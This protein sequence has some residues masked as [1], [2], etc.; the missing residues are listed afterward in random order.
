[1]A[2]IMLNNE[3]LKNRSE[4]RN[5]TKVHT[6]ATSANNFTR[7]LRQLSFSWARNRDSTFTM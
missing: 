3:V 6:S 1:M 2:N 7:G 4:T 5:E